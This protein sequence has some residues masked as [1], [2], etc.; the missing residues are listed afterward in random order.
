MIN[1]IMEILNGAKRDGKNI[2]LGTDE[3]KELIKSL[4]PIAPQ[5]VNM[6]FEMGYVKSD[7]VKLR[8]NDFY[9]FRASLE[10]ND[11]K[12][13]EFLEYI[14]NLDIQPS[15]IFIK[16]LEADLFF[17]PNRKINLVSNEDYLALIYS[18]IEYV[19]QYEQLGLKFTGWNLDFEGIV[20]SNTNK[21]RDILFDKELFN[22]E[23]T[24]WYSF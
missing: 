18:F 16:E 22:C 2:C 5:F 23:S 12:Y 10:F 4:N 15:L 19:K 3:Y 8:G 11:T 9:G 7:L 14:S 6:L 20:E 21:D 1:R 24:S 17:K 13:Y